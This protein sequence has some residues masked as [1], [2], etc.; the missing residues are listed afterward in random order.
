M[1][2]SATI[3]S[4][5]RADT[6]LVTPKIEAFLRDVP[7]G[8]IWDAEGKAL[9]DELCKSTFGSN[10]DRSGRFGAS[11]RGKCER[12]QVF[13]YMGMPGGRILDP[14]TLNLFNDGKW[15]HLRWQMMGMQ[16]GALTHVE[17]PL[18]M[19]KY[20]LGS[21]ADGLNAFDTFLFELKGDRN[22][23]RLLDQSGGVVRE[24]NLQIHTMMLMTGWDVASY[25]ME[26]KSTQQFR[27]IVVKR[28]PAII[29]EVRT[30][31]EILNEHVNQRTL[32]QV[33]PACARKEGPYRT[34]DYGPRC[35]ER[36]ATGNY[37]PDVPG[38][39]DS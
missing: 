11:S 39:W 13:T 2:L 34:C 33:L 14:D 19:D 18:K 22:M 15:R 31:L 7:E 4:I 38:D 5:K 23:A 27:E 1:S 12:A 30:E 32:P 29:R 21:S 28:D 3:K 16:S 8:V 25:V 9:F 6:L 36:D 24:H 10:S 37:W 17:Y 26:D 35:L 20:R